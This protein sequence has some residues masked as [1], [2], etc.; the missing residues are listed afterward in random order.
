MTY[1]QIRAKTTQKHPKRVLVEMVEEMGDLHRRVQGTLAGHP[2]ALKSWK[3][4]EYGFVYL[5][6]FSTS[7]VITDTNSQWM[8]FYP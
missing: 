4:L 8:A 5:P 7:S 2:D 1:V 6:F 3:T